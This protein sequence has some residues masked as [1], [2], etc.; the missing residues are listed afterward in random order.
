MKKINTL[1]ITLSIL[2]FACETQ[3]DVNAE[4]E[5]ITIVFC[6]LDKGADQ[7]YIKINKAFL[8]SEDA[9]DIARVVGSTNYDPDSLIVRLHKINSN[10]EIIS[11]SEPLRDTLL[12]KDDGIFATEGNIIYTIST[13]SIWFNSDKEFRVEIENI[14]TGNIVSSK[15]NL[16]DHVSLSSNLKMDFHT[17]EG[18][19]PTLVNFSHVD[20]AY[21][22]QLQLV[23]NYFEYGFVGYMQ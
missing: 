16:V 9:L 5:E 6:L 1:F 13:D 10:G 18:Y 2:L 19:R 4:W 14:H 20:N 11:S 21:L 3:V 8:T 23:F 22:Y 12:D 17:G 15:T 7:Q